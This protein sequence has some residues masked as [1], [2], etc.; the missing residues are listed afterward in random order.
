MRKRTRWILRSVAGLILVAFGLGLYGY[1]SIKGIV[2][3]CY[4]QW[5]TAELVAAYAE[6]HKQM[7]QSWDSLQP[8]QDRA[9][10]HGPQLYFVE[11][12]YG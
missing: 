9:L 5:A 8:Y 6:E 10:H 2:Q 1:V 4:A 3:D 11:I 12:V 7:P